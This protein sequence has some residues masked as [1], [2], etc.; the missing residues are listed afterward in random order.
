MLPAGPFGVLLEFT[1]LDEVQRCFAWV[2][3]WRVSRPGVL[4]DVVPA[5]RTLMAIATF[6]DAGQRGLRELAAALR[7]VDWAAAGADATAPP[8]ADSEHVELPVTY[9]GPDIDEVARLTGLAPD[10]VV[11]LHT[12]TEFTV[13][14]TG[15]APGFA[16]LTGLPE[17]LRA[18]RRDAPRTRVPA[19]AVALGGPYAGVYPRESPG[20][21]QLI[22]RLASWAPALWDETR[23]SPALLRPGM[24]VLFRDASE[25]SASEAVASTEYSPAPDR[26]SATQPGLRVVRPGPLTTVQDLGRPGFAHLGVP[27]SGAADRASL[28]LANRLVGNA[29]EAAALELTLGGAAVQL[30][31]GRWV[32]VAGARCEITVFSPAPESGDASDDRTAH[33]D[34][35][36][37]AGSSR[38]DAF[39]PHHAASATGSPRHGVSLRIGT[40]PAAGARPDD[41]SEPGGPAASPAGSSTAADA[42][43]R[44]GGTSQHHGSAGFDGALQ[45]DD[46]AG[47]EDALPGLEDAL[48][49]R[50]SAGLEGMSQGRDSVRPD[51]ASQSGM[52]VGGERHGGPGLTGLDGGLQGH[53]GAGLEGASQGRDSDRPEGASQ[54]GMAAGGERHGGPGRSAGDAPVEADDLA[55]TGGSASP[56]HGSGASS[57]SESWTGAADLPGAS[58]HG[59]SADRAA[60]CGQAGVAARGGAGL[61]AGSG[62]GDASRGRGGVGSAGG[63]RGGVEIGAGGGQ[64]GAPRGGGGAD[65]A[66]PGGGVEG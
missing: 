6:D 62:S 13:A 65:V 1:S 22:G 64:G 4:V 20:G 10:E 50:D 54:S 16:Y 42:G 34:A 49:G 31:V 25:Q 58:G 9:D 38:G 60:D 30:E 3:Q 5:E 55:A 39:Q 37:A 17:A 66:A 57:A 40:D 28:K 32:A 21:W 11:A 26:S 52:A 51:G 24:R 43:G 8:G 7:D 29:E 61:R 41:A 46:S 23:S 35:D 19:G 48:Q 45:G 53:D 56:G 27:R 18:P 44:A 15:F 33:E 2:E 59:D 63:G 12:S 47:L 14:F 36:S